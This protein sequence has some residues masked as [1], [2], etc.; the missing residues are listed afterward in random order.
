MAKLRKKEINRGIV[1][2]SEQTKRA[3]QKLQKRMALMEKKTTPE[4]LKDKT[5]AIERW[6]DRRTPERV[7]VKKD[8]PLFDK[9]TNSAKPSKGISK[10]QDALSKKLLEA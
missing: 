10:M 6:I 1:E 5:V 3:R 9:N 7:V 8:L 4:A 2:E